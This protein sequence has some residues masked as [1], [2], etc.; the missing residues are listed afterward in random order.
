MTKKQANLLNNS[1]IG[2][3]VTLL[4]GA[5]SIIVKSG[6]EIRKINKRG[7]ELEVFKNHL[8]ETSELLEMRNKEKSEDTMDNYKPEHYTE[9]E[10][11]LYMA[12]WYVLGY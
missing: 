8:L 3:A 10:L 9:T 6:I 12:Y 4:A 2:V 1:I 11:K 7:I 5:G